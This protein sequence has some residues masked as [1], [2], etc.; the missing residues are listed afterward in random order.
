[1]TNPVDPDGRVVE[2]ARNR[3]VM[4]LVG[5]QSNPAVRNVLPPTGGGQCLS[6]RRR[7]ISTRWCC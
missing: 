2:S 5:L 1:L 6:P 7:C 4:L 3:I